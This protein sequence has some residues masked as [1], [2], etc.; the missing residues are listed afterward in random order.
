M[1]LGFIGSYVTRLALENGWYVKGVDRITYAA[2]KDL[3][4]EFKKYKNFSFV[5][6]DINDLEFLYE[7]D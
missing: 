5:H 3:L 7:C 2:N 1:D 6:S 4:S